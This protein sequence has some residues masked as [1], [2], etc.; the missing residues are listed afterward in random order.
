MSGDEEKLTF[1]L[2]MEKEMESDIQLLLGF[3][4]LPTSDSI[5]N[6]L[7]ASE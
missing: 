6:P 2:V 4:D 3:K 1:Y 7:A 5:G